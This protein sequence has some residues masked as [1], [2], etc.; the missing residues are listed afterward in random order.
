MR[1]PQTLRASPPPGS[2]RLSSLQLSAEAAAPSS[3][4]SAASA[5]EPLPAARGGGWGTTF[6]RRRGPAGACAPPGP[7]GG[8]CPGC[9]PPRSL[10]CSRVRAPLPALGGVGLRSSVSLRRG[11]HPWVRASVSTRVIFRWWKIS[12]RNEF[13]ESRPGEIKESQEDFLDDSSLHSSWVRRLQ[14]TAV[15]AAWMESL[16]T[17]SSRD[18]MIYAQTMEKVSI[19]T[20]S[21]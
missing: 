11:R 21:L 3:A 14:E 10:R 13:R 2:S 19:S 7:T 1:P 12:L 6:S 16:H 8:P 4:S 20:H 9:R 5:A 18:W 15:S 17:L